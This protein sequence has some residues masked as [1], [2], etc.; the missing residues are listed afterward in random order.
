[1]NV[2][3]II[4]RAEIILGCCAA[5]LEDLN[6]IDHYLIS[7]ANRSYWRPDRKILRARLLRLTGCASDAMAELQAEA[8]DDLAAPDRV[9][10]LDELVLAKEAA[11][12]LSGALASFRRYHEL[13]LQARDQSAEQRGQVLNA[14]L[15][16][17]RAQHKA[18]IERTKSWRGR[19][20]WTRSPGCPTGAVWTQRWRTGLARSGRSLPACWPT[21]TT[22]SGSTT[23]TR[24]WSETKC[25]GGWVR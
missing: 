4:V 16:L 2:R 23:G 22:S 21:S 18:E 8:L 19:R 25:C 1:V 5:A 12:D 15:E 20:T 11:G 9:R 17:E 24:I 7:D 14:R 10:V 3:L 6:R 13:T